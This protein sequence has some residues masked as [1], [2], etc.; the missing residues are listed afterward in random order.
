MEQ[1]MPAPE[2]DTNAADNY[3][4]SL[5]LDSIDRFLERDV[6]PVAHELE[7]SDTWPSEIVESM[8]E[9]GLFMG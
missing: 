9:L 2:T 7:A 8:K 6:R 1:P 3:D 4:E 5:I